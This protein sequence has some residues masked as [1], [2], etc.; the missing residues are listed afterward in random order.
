M[1]ARKTKKSLLT[2]D[3]PKYLLEEL[4]FFPMITS[5]CICNTVI[6]FKTVKNLSVAIFCCRV[7]LTINL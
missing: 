2:P 1:L 3:L 6:K 5:C 4:H 7:Q